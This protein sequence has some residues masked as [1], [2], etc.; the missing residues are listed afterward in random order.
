MLADDVYERLRGWLIE[1]RFAPG[2]RIKIDELVAMFGVSNTPVRQALGMLTTDGLVYQEPHRGFLAAQLL[3][4]ENIRQ[5]Y[6]ARGL[7]E[8][9]GAAALASRMS[10]QV[11]SELRKVLG[12]GDD[13]DESFHLRIASLAGNGIVVE[14]LQR[15]FGR[16]RAYRVASTVPGATAVTDGE[17]E[18]I[19]AAIERGDATGAQAAMERHLAHAVDRL[20]CIVE[21]AAVEKG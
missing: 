7:L 8:P 2:E 11:V 4:V 17:H 3:D 6:E 18:E 13:P 9:A 12:T 14:L 10:P 16:T 15:L 21:S 20:L 1:G 5:V 19:V